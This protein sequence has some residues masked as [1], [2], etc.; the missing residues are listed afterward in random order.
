MCPSH[1]PPAAWKKTSLFFDYGV[2]SELASAMNQMDPGLQPLYDIID[3]LMPSVHI[4]TV[5]QLLHS[6]GYPIHAL[7]LLVSDLVVDKKLFPF[8]P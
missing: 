7:P 5:R 6:S 3:P 4:A 2:S 1:K 8:A